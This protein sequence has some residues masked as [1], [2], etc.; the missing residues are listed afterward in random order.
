MS[1]QDEATPAAGRIRLGWLVRVALTNLPFAAAL[2]L[3]GVLPDLIQSLLVGAV[4]FL[5]PGLAWTDRRSGDAFVVLFKAVLASLAAALVVWLVLMP[6]PGPTSRVAF[7]LLLASITNAGLVLGYRRGWYAADPFGAPVVRVL[8]VVAALFYAQSYLG[9]AYFVPPL[10]DQDMETQGTAYGLMH[11]GAPTI[12]INRPTGEGGRLFFAHPL[13]LHFWIA[14]SALVSDDLGRLRHYHEGSL[15]VAEGAPALPAYEAG[16]AQFLRDPVLVPTRTPNLFL[17]AFF[18]LALG[19][20]V[21]RLTGSQVAAAGACVLYMT[22]PEVYVRSSYGGYMALANFLMISGAYFYL[23]AS[24]LFPNRKDSAPARAPLRLGGLS[25]VLSGWAD[26]KAILLAPPA[27][28][29]AGLRALLDGAFRGEAL[30]FLRRGQI[31]ALARLALGRA[32][33]RIAALLGLGFLAGWASFALYGLAIAPDAFIA[34]HLV[35]H[36]AERLTLRDLD[37]FGDEWTYPSVVGLWI[38]FLGHSGW[39]LAPIAALAALHAGGRI[40]EAPGLFL[41]WAGIG[42]VLFS[43]VD[44]RQTKHLAHILPALAVLVGV[45]WASLEGR[46]KHALSAAL[47]AAMLWNIWRIGLLMAD[48]GYLAPT[49][50]W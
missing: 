9:A 31:V 15:A 16:L 6:L 32:D 23:E 20:T 33:A 49:P 44:W 1:T 47:V 3:V 12:A 24:G 38:E 13:L 10:E 17:S 30:G 7:L 50:I 41:L 5:A 22:L 21:F 26:Q 28:A 29:H 35:G 39:L 19:M 25:G 11:E 48:F 14:E 27:A 18:V 43:L 4:L 36:V 37:V 40:R 42:A 34:D 8:L 45:Y 46:L 2:T